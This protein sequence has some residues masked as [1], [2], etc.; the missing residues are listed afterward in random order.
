MAQIFD[1]YE[2]LKKYLKFIGNLPKPL[3]FPMLAISTQNQIN[4]TN[5]ENIPA[6]VVNAVK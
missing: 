1:C 5:I 6:R 3:I 4:Q 2:I